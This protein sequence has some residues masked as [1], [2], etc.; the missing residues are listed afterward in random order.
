L[1]EASDVILIKQLSYII[2]KYKVPGNSIHVMKYS[3]QK[4]KVEFVVLLHRVQIESKGY[5]RSATDRRSR[6]EESHL[7]LMIFYIS[8]LIKTI[9]IFTFSN[10][11]QNVFTMF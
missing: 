2:V 6:E 7:P 3:F 5:S 4:D 9:K 10:T 11:P 8:D 1:S